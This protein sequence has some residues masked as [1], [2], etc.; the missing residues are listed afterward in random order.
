MVVQTGLNNLASI[1]LRCSR[2]IA[3]KTGPN[4]DSEAAERS[5][6]DS[7]RYSL[8]GIPN[9]VQNPYSQLSNHV[10]NF[11]YPPTEAIDPNLTGMNL[12]FSPDNVQDFIAQYAYFHNHVPILHPSTFH[13]MDVHPGLAASMCCIGACYSKMVALADLQQM[14]D[15]LWAAMQRDCQ[16]MSASG[17][18][19]SADTAKA[20]W[21]DIEALQA[22]LLTSIVHVCNGTR[23]QRHRALGTTPAIA[24]E[25][26]RLNLLSA[27]GVQ[28]VGLPVGDLEWRNWIQRESQTR[29][30]HAILTHSVCLGLLFNAAVQFDS[31]EVHLPFPCAQDAWHAASVGECAAALVATTDDVPAQPDLAQALLGLLRPTVRIRSE[32]TNML[33]RDQIVEARRVVKSL[34]SWP[35]TG[36]AD[37]REMIQR[38][39][40]ANNTVGT[41]DIILDLAQIFEP[42]LQEPDVRGG[43]DADTG[44]RS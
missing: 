22:V 7:V 35:L 40:K 23:Q 41:E 8:W 14:M 17:P 44:S 34:C 12:C 36:V 29:L 1:G 11:L 32:S 27:G 3:T 43:A 21:S 9:N 13:I 16:I 24:S 28:D 15:A 37:T 5:P 39:E 33:S 2:L 31:K 42:A 10:L 30:M 26:R 25:A 19:Y 4:R 6:S 20:A 38:I 18:I